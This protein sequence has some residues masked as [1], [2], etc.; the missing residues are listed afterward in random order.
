VLIF[1]NYHNMSGFKPAVF[2]LPLFIYSLPANSEGRFDVF[3][4]RTRSSAEKGLTKSRPHSQ[5]C[6][7]VRLEQANY[8]RRAL[9][10]C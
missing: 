9:I 1:Y 3:V 2:I 10:I 4:F 6:A 5:S 7:V 8:D